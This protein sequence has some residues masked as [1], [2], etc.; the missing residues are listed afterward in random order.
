MKSMNL[1]LLTFF[2]LTGLL[3]SSC[4]KVE[5]AKPLG[6]RGQTIVK[7][8]TSPNDNGSNYNLQ[9]I[10]VK[11]TPQNLD[12]IEVRRDVPNETELNKT[13]VVSI[14]EDPTAIINYN[15]INGTGLVPFPAGSYTVDPA[16]PRSGGEYKVTFQPGEFAKKIRI[17]IPNASTL[18]LSQQYALGFTIVV[19]VTGADGRVSFENR[20]AVV[21]IGLKNRW[22]GHY[23][24][25]GTMVDLTTASITGS[26]PFEA[27]LETFSANEVLL[28]HTGSPFTGYYHPILSGGSGSAYGNFVPVFVFD[29]ATNKVIDVYNG[30]GQ[31]VLPQDRSGQLDPT[32]VNSYDPATKTLKV[33]Y[34][35]LQPGT[36]IRTTFN[37]VFTYLGPR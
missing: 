1:R 2:A 24:V 36:T 29:P 28:Y 31:H 25:T 18:D 7:L 37:E 14:K 8:I 13:L 16:N 19:A 15:N 23:K 30:Y 17:I 32:G 34:Y 6:D 3:F 9:T 33:S 12:V 4:D 26:Y 10:E 5:L 21:E 22:D 11:S 35:M 20:T 27:D